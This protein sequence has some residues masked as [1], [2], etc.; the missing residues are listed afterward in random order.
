MFVRKDNLNF[1]ERKK[2]Q[3]EVRGMWAQRWRLML[4]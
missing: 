3:C 4:V 1:L 2:K